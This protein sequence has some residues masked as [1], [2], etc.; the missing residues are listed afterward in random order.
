LTQQNDMG[1]PVRPPAGPAGTVGTG[2]AEKPSGET[3]RSAV[4]WADRFCD[5]VQAGMAAQ[6]AVIAAGALP[7]SLYSRPG[8]K[9]R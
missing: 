2:V 8:T 9:K 4:D 7:G 6:E 1:S 5:F 3:V